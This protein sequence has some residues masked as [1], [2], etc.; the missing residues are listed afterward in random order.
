MNLRTTAAT[1]S[2]SA[3]GT[4]AVLTTAREQPRRLD[5]GRPPRSGY[6]VGDEAGVRAV[7]GRARHARSLAHGGPQVLRDIPHLRRGTAT[8]ATR[9]GEVLERSV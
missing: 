2:C 9:S 1:S 5:D 4:I 8:D 6:V 3:A 7:A